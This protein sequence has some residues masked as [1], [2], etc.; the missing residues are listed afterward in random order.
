MGC[1]FG[2]PAKRDGER[3]RGGRRE[4]AAPPAVARSLYVAPPAQV[5]AGQWPPWL[6]EVA[7]EAIQGW[8]PRKADS[9]QKLAKIG[10]GTYSNVYKARD[11]ETGKMVALKKVRFDS[12]EPESVKFMAREIT[13]LRRLEGHPNV[14]KLEG[15]VISRVSSSLY[16]VFEYMEHDLAG[17]LCSPDF[18]FS[19][20]LI[21]GFMKQLL[22]GLDHCHSRGVMHRDVKGANLLVN[23]AGVLK[24]ADFGLAQRRRPGDRRPMTTRVVTLWYRP[25]ELL[26]GATSYGYSVDLWSAGCVLAELLANR[27]I[28]P[29]RTEVEQLHRIFKLCGSPPGDYWRRLRLP[30]ASSVFKTQQTYQRSTAEAFAGF[31]PAAITLLDT[32]LSLDP[33]DRGTAASAL[34][35]DFF[36]ESPQACET[37]SLAH[38][39]PTK[40]LDMK[41]RDEIAR[42]K[43]NS[44]KDKVGA[45]RKPRQPTR[46]RARPAP[47]ANAEL[48]INIDRLRL[49]AHMNVK[50]KSEK[51]PPPHRDGAVGIRAADRGPPTQIQHVSFVAP[52]QNRQVSFIQAP[53]RSLES[54]VFDPK[55]VPEFAFPRTARVGPPPPVW[56]PSR[57]RSKPVKTDAQVVPAHIL[58]PAHLT[59]GKEIST[60]ILQ[61]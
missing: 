10:Q 19:L 45:S 22:A 51:F 27:P 36:R 20:P 8:V 35:S 39:P 9:F 54:T 29:G 15:L 56:A 59:K 31:P 30:K 6:T 1:A 44:N 26:L 50:S 3:G 2:K 48:Q 42:G 52:S 40:E 57:R 12:V 61:L 47:E 49:M 17:L 55:N 14:I 46:R 16:L 60:S 32:L 11:L 21:K 18:S 34:E 25:P 43:I 28:L 53:D 37:M 7:G 5:N 33:A 41:I 23:N 38:Y 24:I 58:G 4:K 13:L